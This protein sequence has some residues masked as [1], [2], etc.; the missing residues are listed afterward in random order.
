[1]FHKPQMNS[2]QLVYN[3]IPN[4][5]VQNYKIFLM[6]KFSG[7]SHFEVLQQQQNQRKNES[8]RSFANY[9]KLILCLLVGH[10]DDDIEKNK[11]I[12]E[13]VSRKTLQGEVQ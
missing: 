2:S 6:L 10:D 4:I 9:D 1:M 7:L 12:K 3:H 13:K 5:L 8:I 11:C